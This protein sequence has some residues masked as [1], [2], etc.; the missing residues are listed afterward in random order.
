MSTKL[1]V[2]KLYR[3]NNVPHNAHAIVHAHGGGL[4]ETWTWNVR[5]FTRNHDKKTVSV[6]SPHRIEMKSAIMYLGKQTNYEVF[7]Y[8]DKR[9]IVMF[10]EDVLELIEGEE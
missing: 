8:E 3:R 5:S 6:S 9:L 4:P 2:G 1:V 10:P 7:L